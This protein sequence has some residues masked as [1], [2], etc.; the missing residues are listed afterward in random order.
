MR[1]IIQIDMPDTAPQ[2]DKERHAV[3]IGDDRL[4]KSLRAACSSFRHW[5]SSVNIVAVDDPK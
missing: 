4:I 3:L 5:R 2:R 1:I